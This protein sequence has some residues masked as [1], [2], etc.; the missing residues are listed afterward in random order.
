MIVCLLD[1]IAL[2][3][4]NERVRHSEIVIKIKIY[5]IYFISFSISMH[6]EKTDL[7]AQNSFLP[8][9]L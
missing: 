6:E 3:P 1:C 2:L 7:C 9:F 4:H 8:S 5:F